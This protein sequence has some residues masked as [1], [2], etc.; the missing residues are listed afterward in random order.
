MRVGLV[1]GPFIPVYGLGA[2]AITLC[3]YKMYNQKDVLIFLASMFI[4][5]AFEYLCSFLQQAVFGTVSWEYS[6]SALNIGGR[7]NLMY[8]FFWGIL[9]LVWV[10]D[11]YPFFSRQIQRIP[12]KTGR[13]LT[14]FLSLFMAADILLS[15]GAV[16]RESQRINGVPAT[17]AVQ[18]FFD[19]YFPD[20]FLD[21]IY[22]HMQYVGKPEL[23]EPQAPPPLPQE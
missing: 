9:G 13:G 2:V 7:T 5:G 15:A 23:P 6:D 3:L 16:Y 14:V 11:L 20:E 1:L 12:K 8:A 22:P 10:K 18:E 4:G 21:L 17:N 19:T